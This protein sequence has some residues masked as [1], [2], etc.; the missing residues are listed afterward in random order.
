MPSV[1]RAHEAFK[2][3]D[4]VVLT[5]SVDGGGL[6]AVQAYVDRHGLTMP[7]AVDNGM[8]VARKFGARAV[9]TTYIIN[10]QGVVVAGGFGPVDFDH[11]EFRNYVQAL[12]A[13]PRG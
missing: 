6:K 4:V 8:D 10:R 11:P 9:P 2:D 1:Q 7:T 12:V 3:Q 13:Q 5:I